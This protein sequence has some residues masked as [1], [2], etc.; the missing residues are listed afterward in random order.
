MDLDGVSM[1]YSFDNPNAPTQHPEQYYELFGNRAI[2]QDGWKAVTIHANRMPWDLN[3]TSPFE[4]DVWEL[5]NLNDDFSEA[6]NLAD[7][8][9]EK[10][11]AL[12][13]R[14]EELAWENNVYPLY[15]DMIQRVAKQQDRCL[16]SQGVRLLQSWGTPH[17]REGFP[18]GQRSFPHNR[19]HCGSDR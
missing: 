5:Y 15:D 12:K 11:K 16:G 18:T 3:R 7:K 10:L 19:N 4:E 8:H 17:R 2:Y 13:A 6:V 1:A 9:P 14:W